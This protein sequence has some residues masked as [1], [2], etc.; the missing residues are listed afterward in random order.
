[1]TM[2]FRKETILDPEV[3]NLEGATVLVPEGWTREGGVVWMPE[4][5]TQANLRIRVADPATGASAQTLLTQ[6]FAF[7]VQSFAPM[8]PGTNWLGSVV[9][10]PPREPGEAAHM[11]L[12]GGP[13]Q[14]LQGARI[15]GV[16]DLREYAAEISRSVTSMAVHATRLRYAFEW[17]GRGPWEEDVYIVV[18]FSP[19]DG[20]VARWWC[21][22]WSLRAP[23]GELDRMTPLLGSVILSLRNTED[24]AALLDHSQIEFSQNIQRQ[25]TGITPQRPT[26]NAAQAAHYQKERR[27]VIWHSTDTPGSRWATSQDEIRRK[28]GPAFRARQPAWDRE[29]TVLAR[30]MGGLEAFADPNGTRALHL[31]AGYSYWMGTEGQ[32]VG[33]TDPAFDPGTEGG[34]W[35]PMPIR[36]PGP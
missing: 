30:C 2:K 14:H 4:Y 25:Q 5:S 36:V 27:G 10:P 9:L 31:P 12:L 33:S 29:L 17:T 3:A 23:A 34:P 32:V 11:A 19:P 24:W 8:Q 22:A 20:W 15:T 7:P 21:T 1:M 13:L 18:M 16:Y 28:H 35:K 6:N 26:M